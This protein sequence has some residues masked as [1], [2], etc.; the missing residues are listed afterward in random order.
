MLSGLDFGAIADGLTGLLLGPAAAPSNLEV[1]MGLDTARFAIGMALES[2]CGSWGVP[3]ALLGAL[4][5]SG[6]L[7]FLPLVFCAWV[8][9]PVGAILE[10]PPTSSIN[11][12]L[13]DVDPHNAWIGTLLPS[14]RLAS[15]E[16]A[17][18][19]G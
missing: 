2:L 15:P 6:S 14:S 18:Q 11:A 4:V 10:N 16:P 13:V 8:L 3:L 17:A 7:T 9:G 19:A 1:L 12:L 5:A